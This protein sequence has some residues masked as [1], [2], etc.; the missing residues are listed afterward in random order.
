MDIMAWQ[1][2]LYTAWVSTI[3]SVLNLFPHILG[4]LVVATFGIVI[5]NWVRSIVI[6][7]LQLI[8]FE[9]IIKDSKFKAFLVK[10]EVTDKVESWHP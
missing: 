9:T 8:R 3:T 5:G 10:A 6:K 4:S 2:A 7:S 1:N